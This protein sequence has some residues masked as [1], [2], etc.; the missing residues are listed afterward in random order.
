M[1]ICRKIS[2]WNARAPAEGKG[3]IQRKRGALLMTKE[4]YTIGETARLFGVSTQTLRFYDRKGIL[5]P[6]YTDPET[7]YR[8]YSYM[9]FHIIDRIKYLQGFGLALEEIC[10]IIKGGTLDGLMPALRKQK[11]ALAAELREIEGKIKDLEWYIHY[12]TYLENGEEEA[13][14]YTIHQEKRYILEVPCYAG[15]ALSDMEIRLAAAKGAPEY[16]ELPFRRQYGYKL[17]F[18]KMLEGDFRPYS[19]FIYMREEPGFAAANFDIL[20]EGDYLCFRTR[21]LKGKWEPEMLRERFGQ[22]ALPKLAIALEFEDNLVDWS[23]ALYE[24]QMLME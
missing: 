7:G 5:S 20:P 6:I 21:L 15:D 13:G 16:K 22:S 8:Y 14:F 11:E 9:Q 10:A 19:Y 1:R 4:L 12:F 3:G 17:H 2:I 24:V 18:D 23:D